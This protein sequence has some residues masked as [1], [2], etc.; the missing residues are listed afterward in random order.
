MRE[1]QRASR[2]QVL[3]LRCVEPRTPIG[4]WSAIGDSLPIQQHVVREIGGALQGGRK[5]SHERRRAKG[6]KLHIQK[7]VAPP[8]NPPRGGPPHPPP[9]TPPPHTPTSPPPA[10]PP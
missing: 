9:A 4:P 10:A 2:P 1:T 3:Q 5:I 7:R 8:A 6:E